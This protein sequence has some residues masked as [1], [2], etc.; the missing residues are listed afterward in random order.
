MPP[1][2]TKGVTTIN[3]IRFNFSQFV[4]HIPIIKPNKEKLTDVK[5][6]NRNIQKGCFISKDIN[7]LAVIRI[8]R[9][10]KIDLVDAA[11]TYPRTVSKGEIGAERISYIVPLYF[12]MKIPKAEFDKLWVITDSIISPGIINA[13]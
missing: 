1:R 10:I 8:M 11:P 4:A 13:P 5:N 12:G 7:K 3:G 2:N 6:K 9:P